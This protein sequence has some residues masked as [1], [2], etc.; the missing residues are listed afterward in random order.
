MTPVLELRDVSRC[1]D[2][3]AGEV[4]ALSSVS[5][6]VAAGELV[7]VMGPSGSGKSTLLQLAG[8]LDR[9]TD[10]RVLVDGRDLADLS[11]R[12]LAALRRRRVGY[13]FQRLNLL[14]SLTAVENV[15]LPLELDGIGARGARAAAE[16]ALAQ[17]GFS[18]STKRFPDDLSGG[19]QQRVAIARGVVGER[20]LLLAD[21]PTGALDTVG[22]EA[23]LELLSARRDAGAAVVLVTH[24]PRFAGWADRVLFL[25]DGQVVDEA[26]ARSGAATLASRR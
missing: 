2:D 4:A 3:G 14:A 10:G 23:I 11:T 17:V 20:A 7:A 13:V 26:V 16:E 8:G 5:L 22:G 12:A 6:S 9:P 19:E 25:R 1:Y 21:E 15:M 24:E 18:G